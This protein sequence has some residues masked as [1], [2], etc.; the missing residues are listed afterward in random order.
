MSTDSGRLSHTCAAKLLLAAAALDI[1]VVVLLAKMVSYLS[2][3]QLDPATLQRFLAKRPNESELEAASTLLWF[4]P[5]LL[6]Y[7]LF[8]ELLLG[9]ASLGRLAMQLK[10]LDES[11]RSLSFGK[12]AK[13][14]I[15][16]LGT[17][18]LTGCHPGQPALYDRKA[19]VTWH[20]PIAPRAARPMTQWTLKIRSGASAGRT[21]MALGSYANF[22]N[23]RKGLV[24]IGRD[25]SKVDLALTGDGSVSGAHAAIEARD[26]VLSLI[27]MG[28]SNGTFIGSKRLQ[29][30]KRYSLK[31]VKSF[32]LGAVVIELQR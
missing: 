2:F 18:G 5:C 12:R 30:N 13:R 3:A 28:S 14:A 4:L 27:D 32:K 17:C 6:F 11:G 23:A 24:K 26:G 21:P 9:G 10:P 7:W 25:A 19:G 15:W 8:V 31:G 20:S 16:K 1:A 22:H 29:P